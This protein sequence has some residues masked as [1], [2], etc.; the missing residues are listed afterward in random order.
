MCRIFPLF[1]FSLFLLI[2]GCK[3]SSNQ[4]DLEVKQ[5]KLFEQYLE[6]SKDKSLKL[7]D[8]KKKL[9]LAY[10][11]CFKIKSKKTK[12][13]KIREV[14]SQYY[15]LGD[16]ENFKI[17]N[18]M[19]FKLSLDLKDSLNIAESYF[20]K[21]LY[22]RNSSKVIYAYDNFYKA[23]RVYEKLENN[24]KISPKLYAY[25][26]GK[27]LTDLAL[28]LR[29][30]KNYQESEDLTIQA[31]EKFELSGK[32]KHLSTLYTNLGI[33]AKYQ[34]RYDDAIYYHDLSIEKEENVDKK[35]IREITS[36]NNIGT[37]YKSQKKYEKAIKYYNKALSFEG[38]LKVDTVRHARLIDNLAYVLFL[39]GDLRRIPDL[40][41]QALNKREKIN[42]FSGI[43]T[44]SIH[45]AEYYI[46][47]GE[48][49]VAF[50]YANRAKNSSIK[51]NK[52]D[53]LLQ[54]YQILAK[55]SGKN[56][57]LKYAQEYIWLNDSLIKE[58][59][60]YRD[61]F[62]RIRFETDQKEQQI[63]EKEAQ[64][65][66]VQNR[67]TIYLLG[68]LLLLALISFA[69]FFFRQR[70]KYL[71]QQNKIVQFQASYDNETR[72]SK[73][74]QDEL[75]NDI[76]QV[77]LQYQH[78]PEDPTIPQKLNIAY[79]KARDISRENSDFDTGTT[80]PQEL[81]SMLQNYTQNE[82]QLILRGVDKVNWDTTDKTVK[83]TVYR[84]LQELMTN[85]QKHSQASLV[86]LVFTHTDNA[87]LIR[88][89]DNGVGMDPEDQKSKNGLRNTENRIRAIGGTL[90][91]TA[92][93][94]KG[95]K[96][97]IQIPS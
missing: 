51:S 15:R 67:N 64:I 87:L 93:K 6:E 76:F 83:I 28:I 68:I 12:L 19:V 9:E 62:V 40:F 81:T 25:K 21:G 88:Y 24:K 10:K 14:S 57:G 16:L 65:T 78:N 82:V 69:F 30:V 38:V 33:I 47:K 75:G 29:N 26:Y 89:S 94:D 63:V 60:L 22:Y 92:E 31:I 59:R 20:M 58:E 32:K 97:E 5:Y 95:C 2:I 17:Y 11:Q 86:A 54:S 4:E 52:N 79:N 44:S 1:Y 66:E 36:Y 7:N 80:Y 35:I 42:D 77:M 61:K 46:S 55:I 73:R 96:A 85:M 49:S 41:Y 13:E 84:V 43:A 72:I 74:L 34:E 39:S 91:F 8:R 50:L 18:D 45:L 23:K 37:V 48:D 53:E 90:I 71:A 3:D 56:Q 27:V 70:T